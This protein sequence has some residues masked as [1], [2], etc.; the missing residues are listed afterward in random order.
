MKKYLFIPL[1]CVGFI[2]GANAQWTGTNPVYT[3][4]NVGIGVTSPIRKLHIGSGNNS[5]LLLQ[6]ATEVGSTSELLFKASNTNMS[7]SYIKAGIYFER[8]AGYALGNMHFAIN[9]EINSNNVSL[10]DIR[11]TIARSGNVGIGTASP[12]ELLHIQSST[13]PII[14]LKCTTSNNI[15]SGKILLRENDENFGSFITYDGSNNLFHIGRRV[16]GIDYNVITMQRSTGNVGIGTTDPKAKL[17]VNGTIISTEIK[18][19]ADISQYPDFVFS[20]DYS[21]RSIKEVEKFILENKHLPEIPKA[22]EIEDGL[23]LG[24]MNMKLLQKIEE[25]TLYMIEINNKLELLGTENIELKEE[26]L[27]IKSEQST[28]L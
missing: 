9:N 5:A 26:I 18:V 8:T 15:N 23:A 16:A 1:F 7:D 20:K 13:E 22:D 25:L 4:S 3:N 27:E 2:F 11:M 24:E 21:L 14:K 12:D 19:L 17:S 10:N 28:C 6:G